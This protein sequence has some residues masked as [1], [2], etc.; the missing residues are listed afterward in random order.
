MQTLPVSVVEDAWHE[1]SS[2]DAADVREWVARFRTEQPP[3]SGF[4]LAAEESVF[5][6]DDRGPLLLFGVWAW[7][8]FKKCGRGSHEITAEMIESALDENHK[9]LTALEHSTEKNIMDTAAEWTSNYRQM[10][11]LAAM[12]EQLVGGDLDAP[13]G[14]DDF[15]GL[16]TLYLKTTIDCLNA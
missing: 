6:N 4:L 13:R 3:L 12:L 2:G 9:L 7:L 5:Q 11:L 10:P 16:I 14:V 15:L 8:A 1:L